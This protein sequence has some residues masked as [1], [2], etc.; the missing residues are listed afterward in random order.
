MQNTSLF[1]AWSAEYGFTDNSV[2]QSA[3]KSTH[4]LHAC[5]INGESTYIHSP[6][7]AQKDPTYFER[8]KRF[9]KKRGIQLRACKRRASS[10]NKTDSRR[11]RL[12]PIVLLT[13]GMSASFSHA[14]SVKQHLKLT[15]DNI[16]EHS[17]QQSY[18]ARDDYS[19]LVNTHA[20]T[21][22]KNIL[23]SKLHVTKKTPKGIEN[24]IDSMAGYYSKFDDV[25]ELIANIEHEDW[26]L[27]YAA[28]TFQTT[29][30]GSQLSVDS[31]TVYFD[32]RSGAKLQFYNRCSEAKPF[33]VA[34]P[35]DALLHEL[36]HVQSISLN[37][38]RFIAQGGMS[39]TI[40]PYKHEYETIQKENTLYQA[41]SD[42]DHQA[43]PQRNE[44][45]GR[46]VLVS[47]VTCLE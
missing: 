38:K 21:K 12:A 46:H 3:A 30:E 13:L 29:V 7:L 47:C 15:S 20:K 44:H 33:C 6:Q 22:I 10:T 5:V 43:R 8:L 37:P 26:H 19:D 42:Q 41:M 39:Q 11:R 1:D 28:H 45:T 16:I 32:P 31:M 23:L 14:Q 2:E 18:Q 36:I 34:S 17:H 27:K 35:A 25:V 40:Y 24:D 4:P 9:A